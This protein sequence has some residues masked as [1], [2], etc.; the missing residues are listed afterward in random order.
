MR[1]NTVATI[2][3]LVTGAGLSLGQTSVPSFDEYPATGAKFSG[4]P[5]R[6][7]LKAAEDRRYRTMIRESAA[8][9]PNFAGH[10][11]IAEWGCG[12]GC[13]TVALVDANTGTVSPGPFRV[14]GWELRKY[15]GKYA[16]NDDNYEQ[17]A[18]RLNSRLVVA[19][20]CPEETNCASYFWEW[21]G[22]RFKLIRKIPSAPLPQ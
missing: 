3:T 22:S 14:L 4:K 11:T 19:R 12:A 1:G 9:G 5:A 13:I 16:S 18:Y 8:G 10:Y 20:G 7:I 15:E 17:L 21:T 2:A 6:P